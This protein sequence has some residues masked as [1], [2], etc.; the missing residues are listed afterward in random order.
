MA[1]PEI[2]DLELQREVEALRTRR[3]QSVN[4]TVLDPDLPDL[5]V[6][7]VFSESRPSLDSQASASSTAS[8]SYPVPSTPPDTSLG[9]FPFDE[10]HLS[11]NPPLFG[12]SQRARYLARRN[13]RA[14]QGSDAQEKGPLPQPPIAEDVAS[15][16]AP[17]S[18]APLLWVPA[19]AHPEISPADFRRFMKEQAE[20]NVSQHEADSNIPT[21]RA[22]LSPPLDAAEN[23]KGEAVV[24]ANRLL[25]RN[26]SVARRSSSLRKQIRPDNRDATSSEA[27]AASMMGRARRP[28]SLLAMQSQMPDAAPSAPDARE[29]DPTVSATQATHS[30]DSDTGH[31]RPLPTP[32][33]SQLQRNSRNMKLARPV[34]S[35]GSPRS[36]RAVPAAP[37]SPASSVTPAPPTRAPPRKPVPTPDTMM[38]TIEALAL[39]TPP[40][41]LVGHAN[42]RP[43]FVDEPERMDHAPPT[44]GA[45]ARPKPPPARPLGGDGPRRG[46]TLPS[47]LEDTLEVLHQ[48][49]AINV[50]NVRA[51]A[52]T[53]EALPDLPGTDSERAPKRRSSERVPVP[54]AVPPAPLSA[55]S[56]PAPLPTAPRRSEEDAPIRAG[57]RPLPEPKSTRPEPRP[58]P[59]PKGAPLGAAV[60]PAVAP[61]P[62]E[63][64]EPRAVPPP[65]SA[66]PLAGEASAPAELLDRRRSDGARATPPLPPPRRSVEAAQAAEARRS[67][68]ASAPEPRGTEPVRS[69]SQR[70]VETTRSDSSRSSTRDKRG[71][72]LSWFGLAKDDDDDDKESSGKRR[73]NKDEVPPPPPLLPAP[74]QPPAPKRKEKDTF[75]SNL[76]GKR[77]QHDADSLRGRARTLF[78]SSTASPAPPAVEEYAWSRFPLHIERALYRVSHIKL[79]N[80]RRA[81]Q[82][83]VVISNMMFWYLSVINSSQSRSAQ[84]GN[85]N[86]R[87]TG[88]SEYDEA[89]LRACR[90]TPPLAEHTGVLQRAMPHLLPQTYMPYGMGILPPTWGF[91]TGYPP[92]M[93]MDAHTQ[94]WVPMPSA[95][96]PTTPTSDYDVN[97]YVLDGYYTTPTTP[98]TPVEPRQER[99]NVAA[100]APA[101]ILAPA[102]APT[103]PSWSQTTQHTPPP[104][105]A[106]SPSAPA[107]SAHALTPPAHTEKPSWTTRAN[108]MPMHAPGPGVHE[109][110]GAMEK[111]TAR[112]EVPAPRPSSDSSSRTLRNARSTPTL[113]PRKEPRA[114]PSVP[115]GPTALPTPPLPSLHT[116]R[117][118]APERG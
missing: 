1:N 43:E 9:S 46:N 8:S 59:E 100:S 57:P 55:P 28:G 26:S 21:P 14:A 97:G 5:Q 96:E 108:A 31:P 47:R 76:F 106:P 36:V 54:R 33:T 4:R 42:G 103:G 64:V 41:P 111:Q 35:T 63:R 23:E 88:R 24:A 83:Q 53:K 62:M 92:A 18:G 11:I 30:A 2:T 38:S 93:Y 112:V 67:I 6:P 91:P 68:E 20:R 107:S 90:G 29:E 89:E 52:S 114:V 82:E 85:H 27:P 12:S 86:A 81:L 32:G 65:P 78:S 72:G 44:D 117:S 50:A 60:E 101:P 37:S 16:G 66:R 98:H 73:K 51:K 115:R 75:L 69:D 113:G 61:Q 48:R 118:G 105:P 102:P 34:G 17:G 45:S 99:M 87:Q 58:L 56:G 74:Q 13:A 22:S 95:S 110:P 40:A 77:K 79:A 19:G 15:Y 3:R 70:S 104:L 84:I 80:P 109:A 25:R 116:A 39:D 71:F 94:S 10:R 7:G 49:R